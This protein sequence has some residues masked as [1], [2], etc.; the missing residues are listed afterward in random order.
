MV[1]K[2]LKD[3]SKMTINLIV[4]TFTIAIGMI[5]SIIISFL[6]N[7]PIAFNKNPFIEGFSWAS[8]IIPPILIFI[9]L[10]FICEIIV[11]NKHKAVVITVSIGIIL[12]VLTLILFLVN[13]HYT[14]YTPKFNHA[15]L[16]LW[17]S[18][19]IFVL[20]YF[21][22]YIVNEDLFRVKTH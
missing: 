11:A 9:S 2:K 15:T 5:R 17:P 4:L 22:L 21:V 14:S 16:F 8:E 3:T 6:D 10:W 20:I 13:G 19:M 1:F 7:Q 12:S 18:L